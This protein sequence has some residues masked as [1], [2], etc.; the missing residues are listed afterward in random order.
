MRIILA[1]S[2]P[3][4]RELLKRLQHP[5][6][7]INPDLDETAKAHE[8]PQDLVKRLSEEKAQAV[9]NKLADK[10]AL[11]IGSD[12]LAT[13]N[14]KVLSKPGGYTKAF[15]QLHACSGKTV[16]FLTGLCLL[17]ASNHHMQTV[18]EHFQV[19]FR[20]LSDSQIDHYLR[21]ETPYDCAGS[22]KAEGLGIS[23]F[24]KMSGDDPNSLVGLPL[25]KLVTLLKQEGIDILTDS[26]T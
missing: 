6:E 10:Q 24:E 19:S 23:L 1:S 13:L 3:Y 5:F 2:S 17:N 18:V 12:Q 21:K 4:R 22:F 11:I 16:S 14:N 15:A 25:I 20:V 26:T 7:C 8:Q 9:A